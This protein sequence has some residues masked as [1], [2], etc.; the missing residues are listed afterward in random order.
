MGTGRGCSASG[1][2][3]VVYA[4]RRIMAGCVQ[5]A[6]TCGRTMG[7]GVPE[8]LADSVRYRQLT[9]HRSGDG[10]RKAHSERHGFGLSG[11][12]DTCRRAVSR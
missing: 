11:Q 1:P 12:A 8:L 7:W 5:D 10:V 4:A 9:G 6:V 2:V 3:S